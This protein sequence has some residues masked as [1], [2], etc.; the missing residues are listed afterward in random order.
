MSKEFKW[1]I[2]SLNWTEIIVVAQAV[3]RLSRRRRRNRSIWVKPW[4]QRGN[5]LGQYERLMAE[6]RD[7][8]IPA[9]RNFPRVEP[10]M[11]NEM[12]NRLGERITKKD[13]LYR[14]RSKR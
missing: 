5:L 7:E 1:I 2:C 4:L 11:F 8:D 14:Q 13:T 10:A 3:L 9:F 6:L 12:L